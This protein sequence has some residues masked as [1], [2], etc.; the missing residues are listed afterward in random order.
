MN[1]NINI[2]SQK[3][4]I[5][6]KS[7][8]VQIPLEHFIMGVAPL[9]NKAIQHLQWWSR[10]YPLLLPVLQPLLP[11]RQ[12][13]HRRLM[14]CLRCLLAHEERGRPGQGQVEE[15]LVGH[16]G[17]GL[18]AR[19]RGE[20]PEL[21]HIV[22]RGRG[23]PV[24]VVIDGRE[25]WLEGPGLLEAEG[26]TPTVSSCSSSTSF[27][28]STAGVRRVLRFVWCRFDMVGVPDVASRLGVG[29][30]LVLC[31]TASQGLGGV[32]ERGV[33]APQTR[34][35]LLIL[36]DLQQLLCD[37]SCSKNNIWR[38]VVELNLHACSECQCLRL[39]ISAGT[40]SAR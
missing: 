10:H 25:T 40:R 20:H 21:A 2:K 29:E 27:T 4:W 23:A 9:L 8:A 16:R 35:L 11:L 30:G 1:K 31:L 26:W 13:L 22:V 28:P 15:R 6:K 14:H 7:Q 17:R 18:A 32:I 37:G 39:N 5:K 33:E 38:I 24:Q 3:T 34:Q 12:P 19:A 36:G